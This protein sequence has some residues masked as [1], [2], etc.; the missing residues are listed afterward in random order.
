MKLIKDNHQGISTF[1]SFALL[2][3]S[4]FATDIYIPALPSMASDLSVTNSAVQ[5]SL[6]LFMVS[7]GISQW[8][9]GSLLDSYGR[10]RLG[11]SAL[12]IFAL[13]SFTIAATHN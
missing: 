3:L 10:F 1:L 8:F 2:P 9:V 13:A 11:S 12:L 5:L 6:I 7:Y 4:G